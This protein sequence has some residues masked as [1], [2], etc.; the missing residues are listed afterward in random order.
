MSDCDVCPCGFQLFAADVLF[1]CLC[2]EGRTINSHGS[3]PCRRINIAENKLYP[4]VRL[5]RSFICMLF[6]FCQCEGWTQEASIRVC[7]HI[8]LAEDMVCEWVSHEV[9]KP[10]ANTTLPRIIGVASAI[11]STVR[12]ILLETIHQTPLRTNCMGLAWIWK[13]K[14]EWGGLRIR[15]DSLAFQSAVC[16]LWAVPENTLSHS[17]VEPSN[18]TSS[19]QTPYLGYSGIFWD[20]SL[21][22]N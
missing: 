17:D 13:R 22:L 5:R 1:C 12:A 20:Q 4:G 2:L 19:S 6:R 14:Q 7:S 15:S 10:G 21:V 9:Q 18:A 8:W 16:L 3:Y 11:Y